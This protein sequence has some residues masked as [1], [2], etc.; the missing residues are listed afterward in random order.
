[1]PSDVEDRVIKSKLTSKAQTT[2]TATGY[3]I[4][5]VAIVYG[6]ESPTAAGTAYKVPRIPQGN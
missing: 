2:E 5:S 6:K 1:M 4:D 3:Y